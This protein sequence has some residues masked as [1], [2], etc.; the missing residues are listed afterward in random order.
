MPTMIRDA[1]EAA[2]ICREGVVRRGEELLV[3]SA[4]LYVISLTKSI[5]TYDGKLD[6]A[7]LAKDE[8]ARNRCT[9]DTA[10]APSPTAVAHLLTELW[11]TSPAANSPGIVVSINIGLREREAQYEGGSCPSIRSSPVRM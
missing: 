9:M 3:S 2:S 6:G 8:N 11:R 4:G 10:V 7:P 1:F 5:D